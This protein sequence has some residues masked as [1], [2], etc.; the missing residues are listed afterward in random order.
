MC[1]TGILGYVSGKAKVT[2]PWSKLC[3]DP[4][5]WIEPECVPDGFQWADPSK[6]RIGEVFRLLEHWRQ[7]TEHRLKPLIWVSSCALLED[8]EKPLE[9]RRGQQHS[10]GYRAHPTNAESSKDSS[11]SDADPRYDDGADHSSQND[12]ESSSDDDP[13]VHFEDGPDSGSDDTAGADNEDGSDSEDGA[14]ADNDDND[15]EQETPDS[16]ENHYLQSPPP[17]ARA[18]THGHSGTTIT[19]WSSVNH[20]RYHM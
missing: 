5:S 10:Q 19:F 7:R 4:S 3:E 2:I 13:D 15:L 17:S 14:G 6:L 1:N 11:D 8:V 12:A 20:L 18:S 16:P 9:H